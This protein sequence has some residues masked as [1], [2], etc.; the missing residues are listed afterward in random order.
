MQL[1]RQRLRDVL[2]NCFDM[3]DDFMMDRSTLQ[4]WPPYPPAPNTN[5]QTLTLRYPF[6]ERLCFDG[7]PRLLEGKWRLGTRTFT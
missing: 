6:V 4:K 1:T 3:C 2:M 5:A 7:V